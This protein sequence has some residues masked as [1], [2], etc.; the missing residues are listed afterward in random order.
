[1][2][3]PEGN[4]LDVNNTLKL[5]YHDQG[6]GIPVLFVHGSG[7]GA[8]GWS[9]FKGNTPYFNQHGYRTLIPDLPGY[10]YSSKPEDA[11]YTLSFMVEALEQMLQLLNIPRVD[12]VGNSMGGAVCIRMALNNPDLVHKLI[13]MAPGGLEEREVYMEMAGIQSMMRTFFGKKGITKEG[14]L[15]TFKLQLFNEDLITDA[16]IDE[17]YEIAVTPPKTVISTMRVPNQ[18]AQLKDIACPILGFWGMDDQ[19]CPPTG[20]TTLAERCRD[21][22][23]NLISECG[24]WVMVEHAA[25]FNRECVDFLNEE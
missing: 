5:H 19:F 1:M 22:R 23:M 15:E 9:N 17:R 20:A 7:P 3:L 2:G 6:E 11:E 21:I 24:H 14:M 16:I 18:T 12:L 13:L 4:Y 10:G 25:T 8:S